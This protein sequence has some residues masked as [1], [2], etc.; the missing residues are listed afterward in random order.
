[1]SLAGFTGSLA[2]KGGPYRTRAAT[3]AALTAGGALTAA[4][5]VL[6]GAHPAVAIPVT[7]L[8]AT[9]CALGRAYGSAG[10]SVAVS[11]LN[12]FVISLA[13]PSPEPGEWLVR[14]GFIVAGG[15]WAMLVSL[16]LWPLRPYRPVRLAV[17]Q[18]Y[19]AVA[20]YAARM[21]ESGRE[22]GAPG[23]LGVRAALETAGA[24]LAAV[25]RG[26]PGESGRGERLL[27]LYQ[28]VDQLFGHLFALSDLADGVV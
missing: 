7:L 5:G 15:L 18:A 26:R 9:A 23:P 11:T 16:V 22:A 4:V 19:R 2:D 12:I 28:A 13:Y 17:A 20:D 10:S 14:A 21:A 27:V 6:A 25:R 8:V 3:I 24:A 1:M